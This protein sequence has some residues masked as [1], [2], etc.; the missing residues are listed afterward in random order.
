[1]LA[2]A[3]AP[4]HLVVADSVGAGRLD[5]PRQFHKRQW[6]YRPV[7][8]PRGELGCWMGLG[9]Q[10]LADYVAAYYGGALGA[11]VVEIGHLHVVE[12]EAPED[13]RVEVVDVGRALDG[14]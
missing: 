6:Q 8:W 9:P 12:S 10:R 11:S 1:M 13:G 7:R 5:G 2:R 14:A 3:R 4:A